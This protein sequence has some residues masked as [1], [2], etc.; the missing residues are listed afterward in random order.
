MSI[1]RTRKIIAVAGVI[2]LCAINLPVLAAKQNERSLPEVIHQVLTNYPSLRIAR[3]E[4]ERARQE[5]AKI[6]SQQGSRAMLAYLI[7]PVNV[8]MPRQASVRFK[9][10]VIRLKLPVST[11]MRK[12]NHRSY[13]L[14]PI[15][16]KEPGLT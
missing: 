7:F 8:L 5:F 10:L 12:V 3:L 13:P 11:P 16:L 1:F 6:D 14:S 15:R 9:S 2:Y 4:I